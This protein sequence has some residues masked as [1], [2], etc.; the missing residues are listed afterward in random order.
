MVARSEFE[1]LAAWRA[2]DREAGDALTRLH[3]HAILRF[4][5]LKVTGPVEDLTQRTFL[6]LVEGRERLRDGA[7]FRAYLY[8]IARKQVL[9]YVE[10]KEREARLD[11]FDGPPAR[12]VVTSL[13]TVVARQEE[14]VVVLRALASLPMEFQIALGLHYLDGLRSREIADVLEIPTSTVTSRLS[15]ARALLR[16]QVQRQSRPDRPPVELADMERWVRALLAP[17]PSS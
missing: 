8:G 12:S 10:A 2:G 3:Y 7:S 15:R 17:H 14:Q 6:A 16:E 5:E 11:R 13:S 4:F 9:K 1:L